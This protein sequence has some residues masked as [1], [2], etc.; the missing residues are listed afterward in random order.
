MPLDFSD[1]SDEFI[2]FAGSEF[3]FFEDPDDNENIVD[4]FFNEL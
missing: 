4:N 1:S 2:P 3:T